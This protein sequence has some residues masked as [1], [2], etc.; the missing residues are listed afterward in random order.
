MITFD[1]IC[2]LH[3]LVKKFLE[4]LEEYKILYPAAFKKVDITEDVKF[5][6]TGSSYKTVNLYD[7]AN[8]FGEIRPFVQDVHVTPT[9]GEVKTRKIRSVNINV[10]PG[11]EFEFNTVQRYGFRIYRFGQGRGVVNLEFD[12]AAEKN[13]IKE[14]S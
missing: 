7:G 4:R 14:T 1:F 2:K 5:Q 13:R 6:L 3:A 12:P 9:A 10:D 11:Y 8:R